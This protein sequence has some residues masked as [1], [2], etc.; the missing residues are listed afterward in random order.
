MDLLTSA[1][2]IS[3]A[4]RE[5]GLFAADVSDPWASSDKNV[6]Q[7]I[8][9]ANSLGRHLARKYDWS[10]LEAR[11]S[12]STAAGTPDYDLPA[13]FLKFVNVSAWNQTQQT[14]IPTGVSAERWEQFKAVTSTGI[15]YKVGRIYAGK[16]YLHPTPTAIE[17]IA[18][19]YRSYSWVATSAAPPGDNRILT[20]NA[21]FPLF[22]AALFVDGL[23]LWFRE[24]KGLD[25][26]AERERFEEM[27]AA[28]SGGDG[29][30]P[31]LSLGGTNRLPLLSLINAPE[32]GFG[33]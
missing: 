5:L 17:T 11:H 9:L 3:Q 28:M 31:V 4:G 1:N 12:F 24:A 20:T 32:T 22:D 6:L 15:V 19:A 16:L 25:T 26:K 2:I 29:A 33:Q 10:H 23:K 18:F 14:P 7:L 8:S 21:Q 13:D 30:A 27:A